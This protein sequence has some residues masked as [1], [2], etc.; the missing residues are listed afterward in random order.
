VKGERAEE[1]KLQKIEEAKKLRKMSKKCE[2]IKF[3]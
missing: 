3:K 1:L 2:K